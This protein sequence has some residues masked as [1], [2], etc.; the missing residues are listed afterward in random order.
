MLIENSVQRVT[1]GSALVE[2]AGRTMEDVTG[3]VREV[4]GIMNEIAVASE[5]QRHGIEQIN[6]AI[7]QMD[8]VTQ[9]N[10]A[11]VEQ[12]AAAA[13]SLEEQGRKLGDAVAI[14]HLGDADINMNVIRAST[15]AVISAARRPAI[16]APRLRLATS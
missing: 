16:A 8:A 1:D 3:A 7:T 5:E 2:T 4:T 13:Q 11:L 6:Q 9:Q 15:Q 10:A 12:A 14:F